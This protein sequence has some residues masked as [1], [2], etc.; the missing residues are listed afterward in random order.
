MRSQLILVEIEVI[1]QSDYY[2]LMNCSSSRGV[3]EGDRK[4][5]ADLPRTEHEED[6]GQQQ[7]RR[8]R[9][10]GSPARR[11]A[12]A[13]AVKIIEDQKMQW[14]VGGNMMHCAKLRH[15]VACSHPI[16][17]YILLFLISNFSWW[18]M[19]LSVALLWQIDCCVRV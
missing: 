6:G 1:I 18:T 17:A 14:Q 5:K 4:A 9:R 8:R 16:Q 15:H 13:A 7:R 10:S 19:S 11:V 3:E 12:A 2:L